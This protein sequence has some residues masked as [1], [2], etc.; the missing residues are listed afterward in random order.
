MVSNIAIATKGFWP[1]SAPTTPLYLP[2]N[3]TVTTNTKIGRV[4]LS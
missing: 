2:L 1:R 4:I 3:G